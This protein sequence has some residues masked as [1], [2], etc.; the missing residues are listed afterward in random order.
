M[1]GCGVIL[2]VVNLSVGCVI[3]VVLILRVVSCCGFCWVVLLFGSCVVFWLWGMLVGLLFGCGLGCFLLLLFGCGW[4]VMVFGCWGR[5]GLG[6]VDVGD[7]VL[8]EV[9][10]C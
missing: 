2:F 8:V 1:V 9:G 6:F 3:L 4:F 7:D 5:V 10:L